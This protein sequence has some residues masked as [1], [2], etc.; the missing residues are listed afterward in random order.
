MPA[1]DDAQQERFV[2]NLLKGMSKGEAY[3]TAGY[4]CKNNDVAC[5]A[6]N[7]LFKKVHVVARF[8]ELQDNKITEA[9]L[10]QADIARMYGEIYKKALAANQLSAA[11]SAVTGLGKLFGHLSD[12][13]KHQ[14]DPE[15]PIH[16]AI[17][18]IELVAP[19]TGNAK[20]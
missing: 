12:T 6:A 1:L 7:R 18:R 19:E 11:N 5:S 20:A 8:N 2:Q 17:T 10:E 16:H 9:K 14:G 13:V 15:S 3:L 4:K